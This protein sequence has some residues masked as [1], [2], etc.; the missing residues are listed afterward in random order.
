M[1]GNPQTLES[2]GFEIHGVLFMEFSP[3]FRVWGV[4]RL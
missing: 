3:E 1:L 4:V 2:K